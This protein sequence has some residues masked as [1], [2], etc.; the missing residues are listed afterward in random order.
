MDFIL[1]GETH[2]FVAVHV[3]EK[4]D[5]NNADYTFEQQNWFSACDFKCRPNEVCLVPS[6]DGSLSMVILGKPDNDWDIGGIAN[7]L[8][9]GNYKILAADLDINLVSL[10]WALSQYK[11]VKYLKDKDLKVRRLVVD[12][13]LP[14]IGSFIESTNLVRDMINTPAADMNPLNLS[15]VALDIAKKFGAESV[16]TVGEAL[17]EKGFPAI[18]AV[19]RAAPQPPR[20]IDLEWQFDKKDYPLVVLVGKG[21]CFDTGGLD[22]KSSAGMLSMKKDMGG[23]ANVLGLAYCIMQQSLPVRLKV[24]VPAVENSIDANS[25]R[26]GD[27]VT[28][29]DGTTTE[30]TNTDAEG[31]MILA[32]ALTFAC[33]YNPDL[34][35]D[36]AT[37]TGAARV[38]VGTEISAAF[39]DNEFLVGNILKGSEVWRDPICFLPLYSPYKHMI[40]T[41]IADRCNA[42]KTGYGGAI[43]AG[44]FLKDFVKDGVPWVHFDIM[45]S[46]ARTTAG[47]PKGGEAM[48][49]RALYYLITQA[50]KL[51]REE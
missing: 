6:S 41:P 34:L 44:L 5:F 24:L 19:G 40:E 47:R 17:L 38:A 4:Q 13:V 15:E 50:K 9:V 18:H 37:L 43:T 25:Y 8:P 42:A 28:M 35:I 51:K 22:L 30:I 49:I 48:G 14:E 45:G 7:K 26:P 11:F 46:N 2:D 27:I 12:G 39:T 16:V 3:I 1:S 23:A 29:R 21:V 10:S 32:D 33:E 20:L 36:M 31:R